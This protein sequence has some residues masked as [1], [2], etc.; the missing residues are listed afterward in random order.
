MKTL[1]L[2]R[3]AKSSKDAKGP[4]EDRPLA[5]RGVK[6]ALKMAELLKEKELLPD[7]V[8]T[9]SARRSRETAYAIL[10]ISNAELAIKSTKALYMAEAPEILKAV[11]QVSDDSCCLMLVGHNPGLESFLQYMTG[12]VDSLPTAAIA[13]LVL[14]IDAWSALTL[15]TAAD[16]YELWKPKK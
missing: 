7:Y 3:H 2:M 8:L 12:K 14:P 9:S 13:C 6:D 1:L 15:E 5:K 11:Q 16:K 10:P 4:D